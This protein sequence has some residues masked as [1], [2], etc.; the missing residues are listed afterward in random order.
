MISHTDT[1]IEWEAVRYKGILGSP[2]SV[3]YEKRSSYEVD[4]DNLSKY[5]G[6]SVT[7]FEVGLNDT[8]EVSHENQV[9]NGIGFKYWETIWTHC[10]VEIDLGN[11][12]WRPVN[13]R[14]SILGEPQKDLIEVA[15]R[16]E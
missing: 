14:G 6:F 4:H 13:C 5:L 2:D 12:I 15:L 16:K 3:H 1:G 8:D 9:V 7:D 10:G 11:I